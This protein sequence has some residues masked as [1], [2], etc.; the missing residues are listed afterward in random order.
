MSEEEPKIDPPSFRRQQEATPSE[1][2]SGAWLWMLIG[3]VVT[4]ISAFIALGIVDYFLTPDP[5]PTGVAAEPI[6][7]Q[8]TILRLTAPPTAIPSAT[9]QNATPTAIPTL[10]ASPTPDRLVAPEI[11]TIGFFA[12]V[13]NTDGFGVNIRLGPG[14]SNELLDIAQE[15]S[16]GLILSGPVDADG[17]TWW[18]LEL[19]N[20]QVGWAVQRFLSPSAQPF[21]WNREINDEG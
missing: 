14:T 15:G 4:I 12:Q 10:T 11:I 2:S 1:N 13:T 20:G 9:P 21:N 7:P 6:L 16:H 5:L 18:E 3:F 19:E 17:F 8:P